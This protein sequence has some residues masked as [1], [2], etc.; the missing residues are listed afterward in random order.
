MYE[1][2]SCFGSLLRFM[3]W[4]CILLTIYIWLA[5]QFLIVRQLDLTA[6]R[7]QLL[8]V[9]VVKMAKALVPSL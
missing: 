2:E 1:V 7:G 4:Y 8:H 5:K 3:I 9:S 6:I